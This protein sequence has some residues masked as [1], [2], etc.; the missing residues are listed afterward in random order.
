[1]ET[2]TSR[3][4]YLKTNNINGINEHDMGSFNVK[5]FDFGDFVYIMI[6]DEEVGRPDLISYKCYGGMNYWW[7]LMWY[8]GITDV[9]NDLSFG[10]VLK[11][12]AQSK[13]DEFMR[14]YNNG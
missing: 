10:V 2:I 4:R 3:N 5:D 1:M 6:T 13:I 7:F 14:N 12:P 11:I 9:W 8:N